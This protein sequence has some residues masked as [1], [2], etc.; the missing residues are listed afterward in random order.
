[1]AYSFEDFQLDTARYELTRGGVPVPVEPQ[2]FAVLAYLV[3]HDERV[4]AKEELLDEVW[5][6][7]FVS[8]AALTTRI[9]QARQALGD[10]G[11]DQRL[12][13]TVQRRG[14]RFVGAL[15]EPPTVA[16]ARPAT[17]A[18]QFCTASDGVRIAYAVTGSGAPFVKAANWLTHLEFDERSPVWRH[19]LAALAGEFQLVRYDQRGSGLSDR[20]VGVLSVEAWVRDL[21]TIVDALG[22]E[23]FPLL[24]ISQGGAIAI[25]YA[26]VHPERVTHLIVDGGYARGRR[27]RDPVQRAEA[28][29]L[30]TL[31]ANGW[32]QER[33]AY[34]QLFS[35]LVDPRRLA[36]AAA[37]ADGAAA[38]IRLSR[39]RRAGHGGVLTHRRPRPAPEGDRAH[40]RAAQPR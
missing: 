16:T 40:A 3:E 26:I 29:A 23:R 13:K 1:M 6:S 37:L 7:S 11:R 36:G 4:V 2:V 5:G 10:S 35:S 17:T 15:D 12:I 34:G 18:V 21:E 28:E 24:G 9:R 31:A 33:S 20:D 27:Q 8:D 32:A 22:L 39:E 38:G 25:S 19:A 14:Y 30:A